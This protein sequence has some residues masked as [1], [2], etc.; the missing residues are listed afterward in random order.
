[1]REHRS[2]SSQT[3]PRRP[4]LYALVFLLLGIFLGAHLSPPLFLCWAIL[5]L[6]LFSV[7]LLYLKDKHSTLKFLIP[8]M[9]VIGGL[10]RYEIKTREFPSNHIKNF[11]G[12]NR[13]VTIEGWISSQPDVRDT[14]TYLTVKVRRINPG[15][16]W[17]QTA[18]RIRIKIRKPT[19]A[20]DYGDLIR[21]RGYLNLPFSSRNPGGFDYR[22]YLARKGIFT[23][24]N[25]R[26]PEMIEILSPGGGSPF[27]SELVIPLRRALI[28]SYSYLPSPETRALLA[29]F[30]LGERRGI[31]KEIYEMF[32]KTGTLHLLAVSGSNVGLVLILFLFLFGKVFRLP[33]TIGLLLIVPL[34]VIFCFVT[35]NEPSVVRATIM[36]SLGILAYVFTRDLD[37]INI[38]AFTAL[39]ILMVN[40]LWLYDI[41]FQL[42]FAATSGI[43]YLLTRFP[44]PSTRGKRLYIRAPIYCY[45]TFMVTL[46]AQLAT[47]PVIAYHFNNFPLVSFIA[48][49]PVIA[50]VGVAVYGGV[51]L[52][53]V[54]VL[55]PLVAKIVAFPL[56]LLLSFTISTVNFF[57]RLPFANPRITT[58]SALSMIFFFFFLW[59]IPSWRRPRVVKLTV[60][61]TLIFLNLTVWPRLI[62]AG[63]KPLRLVALD[64]GYGRA[65]FV[66]TPSG[67]GLLFDC[68]DRTKGY[69][70]GER[71]VVP[72]L[73]E[74]GFS[75]IDYLL[76]S[77]FESRLTG[78]LESVLEDIT[79]KN[80]LALPG[81]SDLIADELL[82]ESNCQEIAE[83]LEILFSGGVK[84]TTL[85]SGGGIKSRK[86][87][88]YI[89]EYRG[90]RFILA[91][92]LENG[93]LTE[94]LTSQAPGAIDLLEINA[95]LQGSVAPSAAKLWVLTGGGFSYP[96]R[97]E[98]GREVEGIE[99][100][101]SEAVRPPLTLDSRRCG[102]ITVSTDG[103]KL[104]LQPFLPDCAVTGTTPR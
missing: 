15:L 100:A 65:L 80:L 96:R 104:T 36:A 8:L 3:S 79:V 102:A 74:E 58:P 90:V 69:D 14:R 81:T 13:R 20:F 37:L 78:G 42:S 35:R 2:A 76:L 22:D 24:M 40:P 12:L 18:G 66:E 41:G 86:H 82:G 92:A 32:R 16:G 73:L 47:A 39:V 63:E 52:S 44:I 59:S 29:G 101:A 60:F 75:S 51:I 11:A 77:G 97:S 87:L 55:G 43:A 57:G 33:K 4:A 25:V 98:S 94:F 71:V 28:E 95:S 10:L 45:S 26:S 6:L 91:G 67:R 48:N 68:G 31:P 17:M 1:M 21:Y 62:G 23:T 5:I 27:I 7:I 53:L 89:L 70:Q 83:P 99:I 50:L 46:A 56:E 19:Y 84:L 85:P 49:L 54:S 72:F 61:V 64:V 103:E 34:I 30:I 93:E 38:I 9:L 88:A